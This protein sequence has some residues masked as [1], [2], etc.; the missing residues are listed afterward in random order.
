[1]TNRLLFEKLLKVFEMKECER[2]TKNCILRQCFN[3]QKYEHID[4][5]CKMIV[6]CET[7][8]EEHRTSDCNFNITDKHKKCETREN[9]EHIAWAS[10]CKVKINEKKKIDLTRRIK[11][12]LYFVKKSQTTRE[13]F[14]FVVTTFIESNTFFQRW[15]MIVSKKKKDCRRLEVRNVFQVV[16]DVDA[17]REKRQHDELTR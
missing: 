8:V 16:F 7:C 5:H 17:N 2:F 14:K 10:N 15:K 3:C 12:R 4:K 6:I 11:M 9:R 13:V 1:M